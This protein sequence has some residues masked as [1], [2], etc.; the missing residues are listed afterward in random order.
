MISVRPENLYLINKDSIINTCKKYVLIAYAPSYPNNNNL[1][2]LDCNQVGNNNIINA[3][4]IM[5]DVDINQI[6]NNIF[7]VDRKYPSD[8]IRELTDN[9]DKYKE[10][11][12]FDLSIN[13][14]N[15]FHKIPIN[16]LYSS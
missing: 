5:K 14:I 10:V 2:N 1:S 11:Y 7:V 16:L 15:M 3:Y 13:Y 6:Y 12:M 9:T 8:K 4:L